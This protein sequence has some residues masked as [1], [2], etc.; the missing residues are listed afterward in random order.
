MSSPQA[1]RIMG[2]LTERAELTIA[3][4][5]LLEHGIEQDEIGMHLCRRY[6]IDIDIDELNDVIEDLT[7]VRRKEN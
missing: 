7:A 3:A 4:R 2:K 6:H 5:F 1:H